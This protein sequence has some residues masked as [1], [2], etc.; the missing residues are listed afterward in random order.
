MS[1]NEKLQKA[2]STTIQSGF[3]LDK[4][5]FDFLTTL[6]KTEDPVKLIEETLKRIKALSKKTLFI[7]RDFL[8]KVAKETFPEAT[9]EPLTHET[10]TQPLLTPKKTFHAYAKEV[11][12]DVAVIED[13]TKMLCTTGT[14]EEYKEYFQDRF[15][16]LQAFLKRRIDARDTIPISEA[17]REPVN[18][19]VKVIGMV[20]EKR[21]SKRKILLRIEDLK[22]NITVL[23]PQNAS[24]ELIE[25]ARKLLLDQVI[26][27]VAVKGRDNL[28]IA[29]DIIWPDVPQKTPHK[30]T[31]PVC[32]ALISDLHVGS[33]KFMREGFN[34]FLLWLNGKY[35]DAYLKN[36]A[37]HVKYVVIAGDIVDGVGIYPN[38]I[39]ELAIQNVYDQYETAAKFLEQIPDYVEVIVIPGNHDASRKALPQPAIPKKFAEA[40]YESRKILSIGNPS[41]ITLHGVELLLYHG[42]SLD[43][44]VVATQNIDFCSPEK[45]MKLLLQCRHLAP[46][47][48]ERTPIAPEK[49]D[50]LVI[51]KTPDIFHAGHVHVM[52]HDVYRG[53]LLV[54][55]GAWQEQTEYQKRMG[56]KPTPGIVPIVNLQTLEVTPISFV[57]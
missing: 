31:M 25:K 11:D 37:G 12:A 2:V 13:P 40:L 33:T 14:L 38:Q 22:A 42:R 27:V 4:G 55:S 8:E 53:T 26:C 9:E 35:G 32:A 5:A 49:K 15:R 17:L 56:M 21:E 3:Q 41:R 54:N 36:L 34:R 7:D 24:R 39:E 30:A 29:Q 1:S 43:D 57:A 47:Y 18:S 46:T 28:L 48:G 52:R 50:F 23:V 19:K 10:A 44:V 16:R 45:A 51:E 20:S 6:S